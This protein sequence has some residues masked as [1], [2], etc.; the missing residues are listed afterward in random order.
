MARMLTLSWTWMQSDRAT[1]KTYCWQ[2]ETCFGYLIRLR[3]GVQDFINRK[4]L[5]AGWYQRELQ[6]FRRG[7]HEPPD[8]A[9]GR[10]DRRHLA[11]SV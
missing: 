6:R 11:G 4:L 9:V 3:P 7:I 8:D 1:A 10:R 5:P 2:R